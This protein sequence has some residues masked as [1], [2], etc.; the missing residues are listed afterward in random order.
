MSFVHEIDAVDPGSPASTLEDFVWARE[1]AGAPSEQCGADWDAD[2][3]VTG[4]PER[5]SIVSRPVLDRLGDEFA[6]ARLGVL[7]AGADG[8]VVDLRVNDPEFKRQLKAMLA[9][10]EL[11]D[12]GTDASV[13]GAV[14][15]CQAPLMM[16][17]EECFTGVLAKRVCA[18]A[19]IMDPS[20]GRILGV[21]GITGPGDEMNPLML[22]VATAAA[23]EIE[24]YLADDG[25]SAER[26]LLDRFVQ[27]RRRV[28][29]PLVCLNHRK[30]F[31]NAAAS[32]LLHPA[33]QEVLWESATRSL[34]NG[35]PTATALRLTKG[36]SVAI[37][38]EPISE[39]GAVIGALVILDRLAPSAARATFGWGSLTDAERGVAD[40]VAQGMSNR[41]V[42][43]QLINSPHTVGAHLRQIFRK[44]DISSRVQLTRIVTLQNA[45]SRD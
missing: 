1:M 24:Q 33:D 9:A 7:L 42:A 36:A 39:G 40:L 20:T 31:A 29:G 28:K 14:L 8:R 27:A 5:L 15:Q 30:M 38:I 37:M 41:E 43:T 3:W 25:L 44:L 2:D 32:R 19:P 45:E 23:R 16:K 10:R 22:A 21:V 34:D 6:S 4:G 35:Q 11:C 17:R 13:I 18:A 26:A 12:G